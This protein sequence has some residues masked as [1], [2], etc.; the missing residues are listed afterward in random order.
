MNTYPP[1]P[2][3]S[4]SCASWHS[5]GRPAWPRQTHGARVS[6]PFGRVMRSPGTP[7][8][9]VQPH[10]TAAEV[11]SDQPRSAQHG[12]TNGTTAQLEARPSATNGQQALLP[13]ALESERR[14]NP[15]LSGPKTPRPDGPGRGSR[16]WISPR[17]RSSLV[18]AGL[19]ALPGSSRRS[20]CFRRPSRHALAG[21]F[22]QTEPQRIARYF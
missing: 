7:H 14:T 20:R 4:S 10:D 8:P 22:V 3:A 5:T 18:H 21:P 11:L 6:S 16:A 9:S 19:T 1:P 12:T 2:S 15:T 13:L 17:P